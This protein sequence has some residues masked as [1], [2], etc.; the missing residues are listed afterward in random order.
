MHPDKSVYEKFHNNHM[1]TDEVISFLEHIDSHLVCLEE[2]IEYEEKQPC[3]STP[4]YLKEQILMQASSRNHD[5]SRTVNANMTSRKLQLFYWGLR[6]FV[7]VAASLILLFGVGSQI[8][9]ASVGQRPAFEAELPSPE[10]ATQDRGD[11]LYDFSREIS[12]GIS[13]SSKKVTDYL[14]DLSN[15]LL[16]GG[17]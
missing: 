12:D 8:D 1:H 2:L 11:Y 3:T 6:T 9:I 7:G 13:D 17:N 16:Y 5:F 10:P 15:K 4:P 14:N